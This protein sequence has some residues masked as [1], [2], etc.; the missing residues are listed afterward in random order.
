M[1][2]TFE[3]IVRNAAGVHIATIRP[4]ADG[5]IWYDEPEGWSHEVILIG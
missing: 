5:V 1:D 4:G 2:R 3:L